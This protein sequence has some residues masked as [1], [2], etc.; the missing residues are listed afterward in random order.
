MKLKFMLVLPFFFSLVFSADLAVADGEVRAYIGRDIGYFIGDLVEVRYEVLIPSGAILD[1]E[2]LPGIGEQT[3]EQVFLRERTKIKEAGSADGRKY[4][5]LFIYQIF[6]PGSVENQAVIPGVEFRYG[7]ENSAEQTILPAPPVPIRVS[8]LAGE[9]DGFKSLILEYPYSDNSLGF[10][11]TLLGYAFA[12]VGAGWF[13]LLIAGLSRVVNSPF[14]KALK[15]VR[16]GKEYGADNILNIFRQS[17]NEKLER[18]VFFSDLDEFFAKNP[19]RLRSAG[20]IIF[21]K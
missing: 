16:G 21:P 20:R 10:Y 7:K 15:M 17:F 4:T 11:F 12:F 13:V 8:P 1:E 5:F 9:Q 3:S 2:T 18:A 19:S 6:F 14:G